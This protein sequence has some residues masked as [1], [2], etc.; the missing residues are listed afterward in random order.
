MLAVRVLAFVAGALIVQ[1]VLRSAIKTVVVPRGEN[2]KLTRLVFLTSRAVFD[3]VA[4]TRKDDVARA[5]TLAKFAPSSLILLTASWALI[6]IIGFVPMYWAGD[7]HTLVE[8]LYL[9]GSSVTTLGFVAAQGWFETLLSVVEALIGLGLVALLISYL[10]TIY[11]LF[12]RR[13]VEVVKLDVRAGSPPS[14]LAMLRRFH[15]IGWLDQ[16]DETWIAWEDWFTELE[17]SHTSHPS[18][19]FFRSQ[20]IN[21]SW[22]TCAGAVLD[23]ASIQMSCLDFPFNAR[24]S[25]TVRSGFMALRAIAGYYGVPFD[26]APE[27]NAPISIY[28][29]E[30]DLL[31]IELERE[32]LPLRS[33][34]EQAWRDFAGWRVNYDVPLLALC[35]LADAPATSWSSDRIDGYHRPTLRRRRW[36]IEHPDMPPSW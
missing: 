25:I 31:W 28:R 10:P 29:E 17:E 35:A 12:N 33:D 3:L 4:K 27:P 26:D 16:L 8:S 32:G 1:G 21:S 24:A 7:T 15:R 22:I 2:S 36:V 14:A 9:S 34:Q 18:L 13:E 20:R 11:T 23:T 30:F 6:T 5:A 19:A